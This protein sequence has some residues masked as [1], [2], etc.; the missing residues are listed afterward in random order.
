MEITIV[1]RNIKPRVVFC[2]LVSFKE[3]RE[4]IFASLIH[5]WGPKYLAQGEGTKK[6]RTRPLYKFTRNYCQKSKHHFEGKTE[7]SSSRNRSRGGGRV[8]KGGS[9][10]L[11]RD[12]KAISSGQGFASTVSNG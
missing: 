7:D 12:G 5:E 3:D 10:E 11:S 2:F 4:K 8:V 1:G 6:Y 9:L